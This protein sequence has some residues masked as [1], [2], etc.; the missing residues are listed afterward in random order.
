MKYHYR[1]GE[2]LE[3]KGP[4]DLG[5]ELTSVQRLE[6]GGR[7]RI[8]SGDEEV[9]LVVIDGSVE[10]DCRR[11]AG[12]AV[13]RDMLYVPRRSRASLTSNDAV[14]MRY[15]AP[16]DRDAEF[17][18]LRFADVDGGPETHEVF[19]TAEKNTRRDV[20]HFI[21]ADFPCS[22]LMM[23]LCRGEAGGWTVWP[24]HEHGEQ[25]EEVYVYFDMGDAFAV[26]CVYEDMER[27]L[28]VAMVRDGD[29][30]SVPR[31]YHPNAGC[32]AGGI[33]Y[34]YCMVSR[35][36]GRRDFMD[37]HFQEIYGDGF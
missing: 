29:L 2:L 1:A 37:L 5:L 13:F 10:Y 27:P 22:R 14:V 32:P 9:C 4:R 15:G 7:R 6:F 23:G 3:R 8:E 20:W 12:R 21:G 19:G 18:H 36:A 24:P 16:S 17:A 26:Q 33:S 28:A 35:T 31:G 11:T 30:V 34:I 25:R